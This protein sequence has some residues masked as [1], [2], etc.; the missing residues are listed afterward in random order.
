MADLTIPGV[1]SKYNTQ[2]LIDG[3]MEA[4]RAP[5]K[6]LQ[7]EEALEKQRKAAWQSLNRDLSALRD[8]A[9]RLY[10]VQ[11][12]FSDKIASSSDSRILTATAARNA[13]EETRHI[14]VKKLATA[15]RFQSR[16]LPRD[17]TVAPG[18]Y[19]FSVGDK[20]VRFTFKGGSVKDFA[21]ALNRRGGDLL[22]ASV[23]QDT[24][25]TQ[26]LLLES[27]RTGEKNRLAF[28]GASADL[29]LKAGIVER[30]ASA[31]SRPV[32]LT[33]KAV[34]SWAKPLTPQMY[35]LANGTLTLEPGTELRIPV[36]PS[37]VLNPN[38]VLELS[39]KTEL[40]PQP[41]AGEITPPSGP[42]VPPTG[43]MD[44]QGIHIESNRS[45]VPL[46]E[47]KPPQPPETV[48]DMQVLFMEGAGKLVPL[49]ALE[50][51]ADFRTLTIP[52]GEMGT[53]LEALDL[54]N[55]NTYRRIAIK[56]ITVFDKTQRGEYTPTRPLSGASDAQLSLDGVDVRRESN[57][58]DDLI[59][60]VS[61]SLRGEGADP[62]ELKVGR[63]AEAIKKELLG[64]VGTY[65]RIATNIDIYTRRDD[66]IVEDADYLSDDEKKKALE[67]LG[68]LFGDLSLVQ[69]KSSLQRIMM[70]PYTTARGR[71]LTLLAQIGISTD[72]R[73]P[74][75][76]SG[77]DR[78]RLRGYLEVDEGKLDHALTQYP[79]AVRQLFGNDTNGDLVVDSGVA[80]AT[81]T[82]LRPLV[83]TAG[84][85]PA[86]VSNIDGE[87]ARTQRNIADYQR[88]LDDYQAQLKKKYAQMEGALNAMEKSSQEIDNFNKRNT[89]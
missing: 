36:Q 37:A 27:K 15:D 54:R 82:L 1:T 6:R 79:D 78:S 45:Q 26:V 84:I 86:K 14:T 3:L 39:V 8:S 40:L 17:F 75:S 29:A 64:F 80:Y 38:I 35:G 63:D 71:D 42:Q 34:A 7:R 49:P 13:V 31:A 74:G 62:V 72:V 68:L 88:H 77:I 55:R 20:K 43:S 21:E 10:G 19:V 58:I 30:S 76:A 12:P 33:E 18:E 22:S 73:K 87:I 67:N 23:I 70:N 51:S 59:P 25:T 24:K 83:Q 66:R 50:E 28:S 5:L 52:I 89:Q 41:K 81:D 69:V 16:P 44:F 85:L 11:S 9:R 32:P 57:V 60:G 56:D 61:L 53:S 47:W 65:D 4:E 46:P 2:K 48:T